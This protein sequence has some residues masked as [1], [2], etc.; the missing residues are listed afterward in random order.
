MHTYVRVWY[1]HIHTQTYAYTQTHTGMQTHKSTDADRQTDT[2]IHRHRC[3]HTLT[4]A[5][6]HRQRHTYM[7]IHTDRQT[8]RHRQT[9][10][11]THVHTIFS[12]IRCCR[13]NMVRCLL[14]TEELLHDGNASSAAF[15]ALFISSCV[16]HG[17]LV[18]TSLVA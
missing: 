13:L 18:T 1:T 17:T 3:T 14:I 7:H 16:L 11:H 2:Q 15:T 9:H 12:L 8:D 10:T 5:Q 4:H 6:V